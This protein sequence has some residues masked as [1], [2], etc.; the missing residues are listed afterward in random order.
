MEHKEGPVVRTRM[1][2]GVDRQ[3]PGSHLQVAASSWPAPS[4]PHRPGDPVDDQTR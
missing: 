2:P 4:T 3:A 1:E